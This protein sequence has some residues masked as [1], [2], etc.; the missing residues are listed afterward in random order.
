MPRARFQTTCRLT[1]S[2]FLKAPVARLAS[3]WGPRK[4]GHSPA[5]LSSAARAAPQD[6]DEQQQQ[7]Q[8]LRMHQGSPKIQGNGV[9]AVAAQ[10]QSL[11]PKGSDTGYHALVTS[12]SGI[13]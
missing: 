6:D 4:V 8:V 2:R 3:E 5:G 1:F 10:T 7:A 11:P 12:T 9:P 13:G